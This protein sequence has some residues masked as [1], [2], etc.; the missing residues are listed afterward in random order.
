MESGRTGSAEPSVNLAEPRTSKI[1]H[2]D[3]KNCTF[4][5]RFELIQNLETILI[6]IKIETGISIPFSFEC[7]KKEKFNF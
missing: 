1:R 3:E 2:F 6:K 7:L 4:E 5:S